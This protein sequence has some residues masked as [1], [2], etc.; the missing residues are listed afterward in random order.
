MR[1]WVLCIAF[2]LSFNILK[3]QTNLVPNWS[4]EDYTECPNGS[5]KDCIYLNSTITFVN[6][7]RCAFTKL[8]TPDYFNACAINTNYGFSNPVGFQFPKSGNAYL[9]GGYYSKFN[10]FNLEYIQT[11]LKDTL[12]K[13]KQYCVE[14]Y[15]SL[16]EKSMYFKKNAGAFF[17]KNS[18][19]LNGTSIPVYIDSVPQIISPSNQLLNSTSDW[20]K[21]SGGFIAEGGETNM[22]IGFFGYQN[23]Y[24]TTRV[25]DYS[26]NKIYY[27][28][29]YYYIDDVSVEEVINAQAGADKLINC[30][31]TIIIGADSAIGATYQWFPSAGLVNDKAAFAQAHPTITTTYVLQKTQCKVITYDTVVVTVNGKCPIINQDID[32]IIIPNV[33]TPNQDGV[34]DVWQFNLGIG[35][36]LK[37]LHIYNRWGNL[38]ASRTSVTKLTHVSWDGYTTS[39]EP[40]SEGV[41]YYT[42]EVNTPDK[43]VVKLNGYVSLVK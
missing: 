33:F 19:I 38:V 42:L 23:A 7:W 28:D 21:I 39:G 15:L 17:S 22:T 11:T 8:S 32:D 31:D 25:F 16:A 14:F 10:L 18:F 40:C 9:G 37:S 26:E 24:D 20:M 13:N 2:S 35:N 5:S 27:T 41:Y 29:N 43:G 30:G 12:Q 4:F 6:D 36:T 34:N 3:A 1:H